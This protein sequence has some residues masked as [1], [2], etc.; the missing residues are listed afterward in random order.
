MSPFS[1]RR[2]SSVVI[3]QETR[4]AFQIRQRFETFIVKLLHALQ[5]PFSNAEI[6]FC[7]LEFDA[8]S[9]DLELRLDHLVFRLLNLELLHLL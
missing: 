2:C 3:H 9:S 6:G 7:R 1:G 4:S 8:V 5:L